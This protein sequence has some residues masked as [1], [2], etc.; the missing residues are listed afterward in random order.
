MLTSSPVLLTIIGVGFVLAIV[1]NIPPMFLI[2]TRNIL[3]WSFD[4][5]VPMRL[6]DVSPRYASP[7]KATVTVGV[8]MTAFLA[9]FVFVPS[10]WT[11]FVFTAGIG[12][13]ITFLIVAVCGMVFP[14]RRPDIYE[15]S[16]YRQSILGIPV[17][18]A[19]SAVAAAFDALLI[20]YL[21]TNDAL[22]AN[23]TQGLVALPIGFGA[24]L[25]I[26]A[27]SSVANRR[28]GIDVAAAQQ[29]L[30]PE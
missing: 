14:F 2:A 1:A 13:L 24:G 11:T 8:F 7:V 23:S 28:R 29:E 9:F 22:G 26:Y 15:G 30:P 3:A 4:R 19:V 21:L 20:Y 12:S 5:T 27:V 16:P 17:V 10:N 6:G 25:V 18:S